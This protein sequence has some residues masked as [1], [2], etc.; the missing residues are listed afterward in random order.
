MQETNI[1]GNNDKPTITRKIRKK[2]TKK[3]KTLNH[4]TI[5]VKYFL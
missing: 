4:K 1:A 3:R 5:K 2:L